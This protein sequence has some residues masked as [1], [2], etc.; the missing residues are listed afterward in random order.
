[1][2]KTTKANQWMQDHKDLKVRKLDCDT[3]KNALL[4]K[5]RNLTE[6]TEAIVRK[7]AVDYFAMKVP[8]A[9]I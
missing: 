3:D 8:I 2:E 6:A 4:E 1:M 5:Q 9:S 7:T